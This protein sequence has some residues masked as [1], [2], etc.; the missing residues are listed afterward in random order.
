[1]PPLNYQERFGLL[2]EARRKPHTIRPIGKRG[3]KVGDALHHF[4][5]MRTAQ[6]RRI[7]LDYC[8]QVRRIRITPETV[9]IDLPEPSIFF[10]P[11]LDRFARA[12]GFRNWEEMRDWF[13]ERYGLP[14]FGQLVQWAPAEWER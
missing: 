6:C 13:S 4:I 7:G 14:F 3:Y 5:G 10:I 9:M 2:V 8:T 12:D 11:P 1:M